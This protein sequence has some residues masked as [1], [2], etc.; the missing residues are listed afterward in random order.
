M[1]KNIRDHPFTSARDTINTLS[2]LPDSALIK[3]TSTCPQACIHCSQSASAEGYS[4]SKS[5]F[6][7]ILN[8][9]SKMGVR[10]IRITG[11]D[12]LYTTDAKRFFDIGLRH[13]F[14]ISLFTSLAL[15]L[16]KW[17]LSEYVYRL[18]SVLTTLFGKTEQVH[19]RITGRK[20]SFRNVVNNIKY[21]AKTNIQ[22]CIHV[23]AQRR[24]IDD[25]ASIISFGFELGAHR[26]KVVPVNYTGRSRKNWTALAVSSTDWEHFKN[27]CSKRFSNEEVDLYVSQNSVPVNGL[28]ELPL[29]PPPL[30][31]PWFITERGKVLACCILS[32]NEPGFLTADLLR[33]SW[34]S[35]ILDMIEW[36]RQH[37]QVKQRNL[38]K[39]RTST[40]SANNIGLVQPERLA[41]G[42]ICDPGFVSICP[43]R[44]QRYGANSES[45]N[46]N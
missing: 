11:G 17:F 29:C 19:D 31:S 46:C 42:H 32:G 37:S 15:V 36:L 27:I 3:V 2:C 8:R 1:E 22:I 28:L 9:L 30:G 6:S 20:G 23:I 41:C 18:N 34:Q 33:A 10:R 44:Y 13:K 4:L 25:L 39:C 35:E 43:L 24:N 7:L 26:V 45:K 14:E 21:I 16:P 40:R 12:P 5:E 38:K